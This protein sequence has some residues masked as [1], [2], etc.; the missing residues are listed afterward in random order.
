MA[1]LPILKRGLKDM[2]FK[3]DYSDDFKKYPENFEK[4]MPDGNYDMNWGD[5]GDTVNFEGHK[6]RYINGL[7]EVKPIDKL[8]YIHFDKMKF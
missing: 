7:E 4:M 8:T 3:G 2:G 1:E 6:D 5:C